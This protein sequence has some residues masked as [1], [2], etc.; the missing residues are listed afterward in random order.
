MKFPGRA[1][2]FLFCVCAAFIA[3]AF[4]ASV[5]AENLPLP[6]EARL[7]MDK[8]YSGDPDAAIPIARSIQQSRSDHPL[9][10]LLEAEALWWKRACA[11][12]SSK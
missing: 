2:I 6:P 1:I 11:A 4:P 8:I 7:A 12:H 5:R 9:G 10:Y 3:A